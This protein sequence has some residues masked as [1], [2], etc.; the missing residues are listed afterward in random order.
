MTDISQFNQTIIFKDIAIGQ[1]FIE[2]LSPSNAIYERVA[3]FE[4]D[5]KT[6]NGRRVTDGQPR[7]KRFVDWEPVFI[8]EETDV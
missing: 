3:L 6:F 5:E 8:E 4:Q 2:G 7:Y 1:Q